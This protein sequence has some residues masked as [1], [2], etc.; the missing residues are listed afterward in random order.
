MGVVCAAKALPR[1]KSAPTWR[2]GRL[3]R[4]KLGGKR[5][6]GGVREVLHDQGQD[7]RPVAAA[8]PASDA[9][10]EQDRRGG[11]DERAQ[12]GQAQ[13]KCGLVRIPGVSSVPVLGE[14]A[15]YGDVRLDPK[16]VRMPQVRL[17]LDVVSVP[18]RPALPDAEG[19]TGPCR[20]LAID[21]VD[22]HGPATC[23]SKN[24]GVLN[25]VANKRMHKRRPPGGNRK[26]EPTQRI[27]RDFACPALQR[28]GS[29]R[30]ERGPGHA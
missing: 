29:G 27:R 2:G 15:G 11:R 4:A 13:L 18:V 14:Q 7:G 19:K 17:D 28:E 23:E 22:D 16:Q 26:K 1:A 8:V 30:E 20:S 24:G 21:L 9:T 5:D 25:D 12:A 10:G 6:E 3:R